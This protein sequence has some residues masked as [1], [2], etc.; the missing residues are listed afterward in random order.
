L[1]L[2]TENTIPVYFPLCILL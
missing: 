1:S 2:N